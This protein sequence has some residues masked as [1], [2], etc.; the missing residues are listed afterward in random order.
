MPGNALGAGKHRRGGGF[1][2]AASEAMEN[3]AAARAYE[4]AFSPV[5]AWPR[6]RVWIS[7]VPS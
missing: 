1:L 6:T 2:T 5:R 7:F 4:N 3:A